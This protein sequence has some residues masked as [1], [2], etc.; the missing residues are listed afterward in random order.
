VLV[1]QLFQ[2]GTLEAFHRFPIIQP[3]FFQEIGSLF[4][5]IL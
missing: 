5:G 2:I 4:L 1:S 3:H